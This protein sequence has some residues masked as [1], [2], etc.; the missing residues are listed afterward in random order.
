M[1]KYVG[2]IKCRLVDKGIYVNVGQIFEPE[3]SYNEETSRSLAASLKAGWL[4]RLDD[5]EYKKLKNSQDI[6]K[7][8]IVSSVNVK[9]VNNMAAKSV[10]CSTPVGTVSDMSD[11]V[12]ADEVIDQNVIIASMENKHKTNT[13]EVVNDI[14]SEIKKRIRRTKSDMTIKKI[15]KEG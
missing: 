6:N 8:H 3:D 4:R 13:V 11:A 5:K 15:K 10:E 2:M 14:K 9:V 7:K 1:N 12:I